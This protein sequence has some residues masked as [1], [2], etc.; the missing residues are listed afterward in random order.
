MSDEVEKVP[1]PSEAVNA[2]WL[3]DAIV[4]LRTRGGII[5]Q[6]GCM[7]LP[8]PIFNE[9]CER[10][11]GAVGRDRG[12]DSVVEWLHGELPDAPSRSAIYRFAGYLREEYRA[13]RSIDRRRSAKELVATISDGEPEALQM[14][15]NLN[16]TERLGD[17]L[18]SCG[19]LASL[20]PKTFAATVAGVRAV[21]QT[22]FDKR[23]MDKALQRANAQIE[24]LEL[25]NQEMKGKFEAAAKTLQTKA[26]GGR[27]ITD[28][29]IAEARRA[30]F[31]GAS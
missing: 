23:K 29:D 26:S 28:Q 15:L 14:A 22:A 16:L 21:S 24:R 20:D 17:M 6:L 27:K 12:V 5:A 1:T 8:T 9:L 2:A 18:D 19:D 31:G 30:I 3:A 13:A 11:I 10:I 4:S 25:L 7:K